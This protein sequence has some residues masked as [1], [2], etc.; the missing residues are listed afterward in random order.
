[1][2]SSDSP[3]RSPEQEERPKP[4]KI[5]VTNLDVEV[6]QIIPRWRP[7]NSRP[8]CNRNLQDSGG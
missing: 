6:P 5:F 1:M 7:V 3:R 4:H 8:N 2:S